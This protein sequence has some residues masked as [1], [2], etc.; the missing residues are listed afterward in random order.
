MVV[1][2]HPLRSDLP[3]L[4]K[5]APIILGQPFVANR[6]VEALHVGILLGLARLDVFD[7]DSLAIGPVQQRSADVL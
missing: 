3:H 4:F 6:S 2:P 7:A 5:V 1:A